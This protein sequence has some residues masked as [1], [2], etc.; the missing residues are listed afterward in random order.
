M[1]MQSSWYGFIKSALAIRCPI[2][3]SPLQRLV[4]MLYQAI[5]RDEGLIIQQM[6]ALVS[7]LDHM[8]RQTPF[9]MR[10]EEHVTV[11]K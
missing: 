7:I 5:W 8:L 1:H 9:R 4:D 10:Y 2:M 3:P 6:L 11:D